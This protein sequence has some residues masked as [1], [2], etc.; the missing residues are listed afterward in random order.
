[1]SSYSMMLKREL[2]SSLEKRH[3]RIG[4]AVMAI[5]QASGRIIDDET[6]H[7]FL[8]QSENTAL[9]KLVRLY[10][11][12]VLNLKTALNY[13]KASGS[14]SKKRY[15]L[16]I[17]DAVSL[18]SKLKIEYSDT[19]LSYE[20]DES[21]Y[22]NIR[23]TK[24]YLIGFFLASGFMSDPKKSYH[25]E[26]V[27]RQEEQA[28]ALLELLSA[29][30]FNL[31]KVNRLSQTIVYVKD[32]DE[33]ADILSAMDA[34]SARFSFEDEKIMKQIVNDVNRIVNCELSNLA[35]T[36]DTARRQINAIDYIDKTLGLDKLDKNLRAAAELRRA[37][38][39]LNLKELGLQMIPALGKSGMN[40]RL[41]KLEE[42]ALTLRKENNM[43]HE[44]RGQGVCNE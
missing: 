12:K 32:S 9:I 36:A 44:K 35:R 40:H 42:I 15:S 31:R 6:G 25:L 30:S 34:V 33:I 18:L 26:F 20:I 11:E 14:G 13:N 10:F 17:E 8:M 16:L 39:D 28:E 38:P 29:L 7:K 43:Q 19:E 41:N 23:H 4:Y 24:D 3:N 22:K 1:M 21:V 5:C 37:R 27:C 2:I